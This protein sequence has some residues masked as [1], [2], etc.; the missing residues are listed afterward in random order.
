MTIALGSLLAFLAVVTGAFGAHAL[1]KILDAYGLKVWHTAVTYHMTHAI[2]LV[3]LGLFERQMGR[4]Y[5]VT[6]AL[7]AA[8]ILIFSGSLYLLAFTGVKWLGAITPIGGA[9]FLAAWLS[10]AWYAWKS[11]L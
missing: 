7:F 5:P 1:E 4:T 9:C 11:Q 3:L 6:L 10:F 8:G 2:A